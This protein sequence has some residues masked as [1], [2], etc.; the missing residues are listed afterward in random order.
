MNAEEARRKEEQQENVLEVTIYTVSKHTSNMSIGFL[1]IM[2]F[3]SRLHV[4][5]VGRGFVIFK[6]SITRYFVSLI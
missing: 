1:S 2:T 6:T 4:V 5:Q 3:L